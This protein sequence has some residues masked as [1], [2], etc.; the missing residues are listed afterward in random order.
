[1]QV[2]KLLSYIYE[3]MN[4][5]PF[6]LFLKNLQ[7]FSALLS[8]VFSSEGSLQ[9]SSLGIILNIAWWGI[10]SRQKSRLFSHFIKYEAA[11]RDNVLELHI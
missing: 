5:S 1:M 9:I 8:A 10:K 11:Y 2:T 3:I 6:S 7:S 4:F